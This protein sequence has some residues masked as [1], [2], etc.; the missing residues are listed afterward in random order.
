MVPLK[1]KLTLG[2]PV[3]VDLLYRNL[4]SETTNTLSEAEYHGL[5]IGTRYQ[6]D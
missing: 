2:G 6:E 3:V 4:Q 1:Q 5:H